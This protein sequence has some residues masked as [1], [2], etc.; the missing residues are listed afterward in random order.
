MV[1]ERECLRAMEEKFYKPE[2][3]K[4]DIKLLIN[5]GE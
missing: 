1:L 2:G 4:E 5:N 3:G